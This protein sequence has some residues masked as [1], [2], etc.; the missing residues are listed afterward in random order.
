[1]ALPSPAREQVIRRANFEYLADAEDTDT[2]GLD[3][4]LTAMGDDRGL[5]LQVPG[6]SKLPNFQSTGTQLIPK[7]LMRTSPHVGIQTGHIAP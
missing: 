1:V 4:G 5:H 2:V 3:A 7:I 6:A